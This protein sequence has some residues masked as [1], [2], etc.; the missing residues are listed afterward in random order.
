M[1]TT[2][3]PEEVIFS[4]IRAIEVKQEEYHAKVAEINDVRFGL[5]ELLKDT[6][7][8]VDC[9]PMTDEQKATAK[10]NLFSHVERILAW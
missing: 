6:P 9:T 3:T 8:N 7:K 5:Q 1:V 2:P 10:T 4:K